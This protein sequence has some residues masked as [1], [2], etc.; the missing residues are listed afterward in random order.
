MK[1]QLFLFIL[2]LLCVPLAHGQSFQNPLQGPITSTSAAC[3]VAG[4]Q[5]CVWQK[6]SATASVATVQVSGTFS[7]TL[8]VEA[9]NGGASF[10]TLGTITTAGTTSYVVAGFTDFRVR[11]SAYTSGT[12][13]TTINS[14]SAPSGGVTSG[15]ADATGNACAANALYVRTTNGALY[16]CNAGVFAIV[17]GG[18]GTVTSVSGSAP[19]VSSGGNTPAISCPTCVTSPAA[20][21]ANTLVIGGGAQ[22]ASALG[23]LGTTTTLLHGNAA[24]APTYGPVALATDVSGQLPI[25]AVGSAGLSGTSP[26]AIASTGVISCPTCNTSAAAITSNVLPKGS[27]GAQGLANSSITDNGTNVTASEPIVSTTEVDAGANGGAAGVIGLNGSTSG[28]QT[29]TTNAT[30]G[31]MTCT[32][33]I[34]ATGISGSSQYIINGRVWGVGTAPTI[35]GAGCGGSGASVATVAGSLTFDINVGTAPTAAGCIV[36]LPTVTTGYNCSVNDFTTISTAVSM[37]KQTAKSTNSITLQNFSDV[38]VATAPT[39]NDIYHVQCTA[40]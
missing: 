40:D 7:A 33:T 2:A 37:Q 38:T 15:T 11:A 28:K 30:A 22:A 13:F 8:T 14:S 3:A 29:C 19:I 9:N 26:I 31:S 17:G 10:T 24:G 5:S 18:G 12:A 23:S 21:T 34:V 27:G 4:D 6:L 20:L 1:K 39:A 16:T 32:G 35:A 36:T 25:A